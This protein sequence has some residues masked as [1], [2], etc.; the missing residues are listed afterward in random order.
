MTSDH[1]LFSFLTA[2]PNAEVGA[3]HEKAVPVCLLT[4]GDRELWMQAE[5]EAALTLQRP[6]KD[7]TLRVVARGERQDG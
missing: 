7:G 6:A 4:E 5:A 2:E 1:M 3:V